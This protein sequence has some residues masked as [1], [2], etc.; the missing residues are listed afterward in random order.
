M[1][2]VLLSAFL[3]SIVL[4]GIHSYFGLEIIKR[5]IIFTDLAIGQMSAVGAAVSL[6]FFDGN[7][8]YLISLL[9]ALIGGYSIAYATRRT[10]NVEAFIGLLYAFGVSA[11]FIILSKT[12][13]GMEVFQRLLAADILFTPMEKIIKVAI[14]YSLLGGVILFFH[15]KT[16]GFLRDMLFFVTFA[17]TVT[18]S[19]EMAGVMVVFALLISPALISMCISRGILLINAWIIGI[20]INLIAI[21]LSY[22]FDLPTGYAIVFCNALTAAVVNL[23]SK[24]MKVVNGILK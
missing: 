14:I 5:G 6:L 9:F 4:V 7:Y 13:H 23:I 10:T 20:M 24:K 17:V 11:V 22:N 1:T 3:L 8:I 12:D 18:S 15:H 2:D 19:V 21:L 16:K